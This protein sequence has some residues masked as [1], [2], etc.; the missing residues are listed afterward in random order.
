MQDFTRPPSFGG[1][2]QYGGQVAPR[3][4]ELTSEAVFFQKV[5]TWMC[6]ALAL[7]G[8]TGYI[9]SH[10]STWVSMLVGSSF[11][12][13][14]IIILQ[15]GLVLLISFLFNT[16]SSTAVRALYLAYAVSM[17]FTVSLVLLVY[18]PGVIV[19][20]FVSTAGIYGAMAIYGVMTRRSLQ[21]WGGFLF[22]GL[23]G[24]ILASVV[25]IFAKSSAMDF[26]ICIVG[27]LVF[28]GLTA[29]DHQKLRVIHAGGFGS[30]EEESK[31]VSMGALQ[32]YLDF[33][34]I[35]FFLLRLFGRG[36]D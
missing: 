32:L 4:A 19:K 7:T 15:L 27:V 8:F 12:A 6:G 23:V 22:M 25:N 24:V 11:L 35:F 30:A 2:P 28:A 9:L 3:P 34:N 26:V 36:G 17:G 31:A 1:P 14:A 20:A 33:V 10:S 21:A 18:D 13:W 29:Y 16:L 5:Y